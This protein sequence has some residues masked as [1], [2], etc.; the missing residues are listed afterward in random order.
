MRLNDDMPEMIEVINDLTLGR[1]YAVTAAL[2]VLAIRHGDAGNEITRDWL[3]KTL[4]VLTSS[5]KQA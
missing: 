1:P 4:G 5:Q 2:V 3:R